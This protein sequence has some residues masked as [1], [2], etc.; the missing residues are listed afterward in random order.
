[1]TS[2]FKELWEFG[3]S[4]WED[5]K[6]I[7]NWLLGNKPDIPAVSTVSRICIWVPYYFVHLFLIGIFLN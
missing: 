7:F 4:L 1:M 6:K 3:K 5:G 2:I